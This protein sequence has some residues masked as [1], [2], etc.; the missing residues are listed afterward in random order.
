MDHVSTDRVQGPHLS[1]LGTGLV[2]A[3]N[4]AEE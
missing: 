1:R 2:F 3:M 4:R